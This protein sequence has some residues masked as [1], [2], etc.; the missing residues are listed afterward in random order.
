M[1]YVKATHWNDRLKV[2]HTYDP[3]HLTYNKLIKDRYKE[4]EQILDVYDDNDWPYTAQDILDINYKKWAEEQKAKSE[5]AQAAVPDGL[6]LFCKKVMVTRF[7]KAEQVVNAEKY[8]IEAELYRRY[9]A[10]LRPKKVDIAMST[11]T[12]DFVNGFFRYLREDAKR[13]VS[14]DSTLQRHLA[15]LMAILRYARDQ[16]VI[17]K[18][19]TLEVQLNVLKSKKVKLNNAQI[20]LMLNGPWPEEW[21]ATKGGQTSLQA[22]DTF[23]LQFYLYGARVADVMLLRN[24]NIISRGGVPVKIEFYQKKGRRKEGK[25]LMSIPIPP[26]ALSVVSRYWKADK[27]EAYL[28]PWLEYEPDVTRTTAENKLLMEEDIG[29]AT[30]RMNAGLR[31]LESITNTELSGFT[32]H[33]ARHSYAQRAKRKGKSI[34]W[35]KETLG[36]SNYD[37]TAGYLD[38]LDADELNQNM[39]DVYD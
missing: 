10:T 37:I 22:I 34:E 3:H 24:R 9:L 33:S 25:R 5:V 35:I 17:S 2:V 15:Q 21:A 29:R 30:S 4:I 7:Y 26:P 12:V 18:V 32:S 31:R 27:P 28:I 1:C 23:L 14:K 11:L 39:Q 38:D 6:I 36:H 16:G 20:D 19:P 13:K 8:E